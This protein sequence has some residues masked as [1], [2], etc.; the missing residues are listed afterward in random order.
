MPD[1]EV[2]ACLAAL[3]ARPAH[4]RLTGIMAHASRQTTD[5]GFWRAY[6]REVG[7]RT[8]A[9]A[10]AMGGGWRPQEVDLGG[11]FA[12]PRDPTARLDA[13]RRDAPRAPE[14]EAYCAALAE[15][16]EEGLRAGGLEPDGIALQIEPGRGVYADAG[17]HL[18]RVLHVKQQARP[19]ARR[20]IETDTSEAFLGDVNLERSR[21]AVVVAGAP[22]R[23][24]RTD[25][26]VTG[27]S[28]GFDVLVPDGEVPD[29]R[30]GDLLAF[31]D[32][33]AYQEAASSNFN[34]MPRPAT[35]LVSGAEAR[36]V[37]RA[38]TLE[39]L[40]AREDA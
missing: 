17:V 21:F 19:V 12:P 40:L 18:A 14:P 35:V 4:A 27:I 8:G 37:R 25:S 28:C 15:G 33:G 26:A 38:E 20:W 23:P 32:T 34:A 11:G 3:A 30:A 5:L 39:D 1:E 9:A 10:Q 6:A 31:L 29:A 16:L 7:R 22:E 13:E 2:E 24:M 36:V